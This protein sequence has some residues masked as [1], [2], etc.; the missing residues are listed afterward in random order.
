M[1]TPSPP[2]DTLALASAHAL[3]FALCSQPRCG[4]GEH[5]VGPCPATRSL[6]PTGDLNVGQARSVAPRGTATVATP[7]APVEP[8]AT[9]PIM[10]GRLHSAH[11]HDARPQRMA[12]RQFV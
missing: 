10:Q 1:Q 2:A 6:C 5:P 4:C 7:L 12:L 8:A 3:A 9:T 11:C